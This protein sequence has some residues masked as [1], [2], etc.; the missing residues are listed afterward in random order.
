MARTRTIIFI[1][2]AL[3]FILTA[4]APSRPAAPTAVPATP[5]PA[6]SEQK[7]TFKSGNL[8]L[9][10][11][12][13]KP[14]GDG[15]FPALVW[16]HGREAH[17]D[18]GSEFDSIAA[19]FVPEGYVVFAPVRRGQGG[20]DGESIEDEIK[21][22]RERNGDAAAQVLFA[23]LMATE[24]L[25]D[26]LAGLAYLESQPFVDRDRI[27]V[28]GCADGGV[29]AI[30]G[31]AAD[32]SYKAA[33]AI[34]PASDNWAANLPLQTQLLQAVGSID[35][36][37]YIFHASQDA[38]KDPGRTLAKEFE[39]LRK[40]YRLKIYTP[41]GTPEQQTTCFGGPIGVEIWKPEA[42]TFFG[43]VLR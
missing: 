33:V 14:A 10:G 5:T 11:F 13:Y 26:Q 39:R 34:S 9:E 3:A 36:P 1:L 19:A 22:E 42:L 15:P 30:L 38:N 24:Q 31:A 4:C 6:A 12:L 41:F 32:H 7:L 43:Q 37:V 27:G 18:E 16:N 2:S 28:M 35:V 40:T 20:S 8:T 21:E 17:P 25:D 29:Q 23:K